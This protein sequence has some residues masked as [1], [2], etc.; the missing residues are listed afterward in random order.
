MLP[1]Q[2]Q[3]PGASVRG[4]ERQQP[5]LVRLQAQLEGK[6]EEVAAL[7]RQVKELQVGGGGGGWGGGGWG[8]GWV[9]GGGG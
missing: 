4:S 2:Q 9:G 5:A 8:G 3:Q 6:V 1:L 7:Q